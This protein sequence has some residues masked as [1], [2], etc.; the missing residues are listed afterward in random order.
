M[1]FRP[2]RNDFQILEFKKDDIS[3][4]A[5]AGILTFREAADMADDAYGEYLDKCKCPETHPCEECIEMW[6]E[7]ENFENHLRYN[8]CDWS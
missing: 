4:R 5:D 2:S 8:V 6:Q 1:P 7:A 3:D